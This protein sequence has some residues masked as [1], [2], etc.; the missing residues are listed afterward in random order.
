MPPIVPTPPQP[1]FDPDALDWTDD[2]WWD[3][4]GPTVVPNLDEL[5][6]EDGAPVENIYAEKQY[7]LLTE[8]LYSSWTGPGEGRPFL[9]LTN[10]GWFYASKQPPLVPDA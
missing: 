6:T 9:A 7:R 2:R 1:A 8:P 4:L 3:N 10:V 5:V